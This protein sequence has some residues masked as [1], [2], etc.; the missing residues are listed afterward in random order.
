M[1]AINVLFGLDHGKP[2]QTAGVTNYVISPRFHSSDHRPEA[3][4]DDWALITLDRDLPLQPLA[5]RPKTPN[6]LMAMSSRRSLFEIGY[7]VERPYAPTIASPCQIGRVSAG[8][9]SFE[10]LSNHGYS[11]AP[12]LARSGEVV[13]IVGLVSRRSVADPEGFA[14]ALWNLTI[15]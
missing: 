8:A 11:G 10:C 2:A 3:A 5:V 12:I 13:E 7:G 9:F 14:S 6:E 15:P 4:A 1:D